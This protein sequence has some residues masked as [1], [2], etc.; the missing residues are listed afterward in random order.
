MVK[1]CDN[2]GFTLI[3]SLIVIFIVSTMSLVLVAKPFKII[4]F[5]RPLTHYQIDAM[6]SKQRV[7]FVQEHWFNGDGNANR[8]GRFSYF[9]KNCLVYLGYG[10]YVCD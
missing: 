1:Q 6:T 9:Q 4:E 5:R 3:E 10:R 2:R 8:S 7:N